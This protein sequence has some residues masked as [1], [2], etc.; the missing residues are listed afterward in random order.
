MNQSSNLVNKYDERERDSS[1]SFDENLH[2]M[3]NGASLQS[4]VDDI[5]F[6]FNPK[7]RTIIIVSYF[8][9]QRYLLLFFIKSDIDIPEYDTSQIRDILSKPVIF[10]C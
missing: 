5:P 4:Y 8:L 6:E 1:A 10:I 3:N 7:Y 2:S 9:Y